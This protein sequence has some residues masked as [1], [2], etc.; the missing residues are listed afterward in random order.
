M[1][2]TTR[3]N[4]PKTP[5]NTRGAALVIGLLILL[6]MTLIGTTSME[7]S[8][9]EGRMASNSRDLNTAFQASE[10]AMQDAEEYTSSTLK[11]SDF[12]ASQDGLYSYEDLAVG[13]TVW[14]SIDWD[15]SGTTKVV[16]TTIAG[17]A[18]SASYILERRPQIVYEDNI[19]N[20]DLYGSP[21]TR[22][23]HIIRITTRGIGASENSSVFLQTTYG[24]EPNK[25]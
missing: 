11:A 6:V 4:Q 21:D 10:A 22:G 12:S 14:T 25:F 5:K 24:I 19:N 2:P 20:N 8:I 1:K 9:L 16:G 3:I 17:V 18:S 13:S 23:A 15:G 7:G